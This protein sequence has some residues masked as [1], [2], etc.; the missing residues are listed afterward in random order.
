MTL[1]KELPAF[2]SPMLALASEPFDSDQDLFELKW[3]G[4][5]AL[6]FHDQGGYRIRNRHGVDITCRYPEFDCFKE[7]ERGAVLDGEIVVLRGRSSEHRR[8]KSRR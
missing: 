1:E 8:R 2:V 3:D 6:V 5:R 4:I 7:L